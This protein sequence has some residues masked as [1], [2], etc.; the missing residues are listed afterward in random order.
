TSQS[1]SSSGVRMPEAP[2]DNWTCS[3]K[4]RLSRRSLSEGVLWGGA[5]VSTGTRSLSTETCNKEPFGMF[6]RR[7]EVMKQFSILAFC[8]ISGLAITTSVVEGQMNVPVTQNGSHAAGNGT[9]HAANVHP[10]PPVDQ[11]IARR[12]A[13]L[14]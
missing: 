11:K 13:K 9:S 14:S 6:N 12:P 4:R 1:L 2:D 5:H 10:S 7:S 8:L 3:A